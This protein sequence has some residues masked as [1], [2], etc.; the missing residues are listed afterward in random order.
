PLPLSWPESSILDSPINIPCT[1]LDMP[2]LSLTTKNSSSLLFLIFLDSN[3]PNVSLPL[4][5][6]QIEDCQ[7]KEI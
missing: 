4:I 2:L 3:C 7:Y 1:L 6:L 5:P